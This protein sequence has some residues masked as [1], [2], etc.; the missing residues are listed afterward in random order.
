M[1]H[2]TILEIPSDLLERAQYG[3]RIAVCKH[4]SARPQ[5]SESL[6]AASPRSCEEK[7]ELFKQLPQ[8]LR[9]A[10]CIDPMVGSFE[11]IM[12]RHLEE[13]SQQGSGSERV[14]G[15]ASRRGRAWSRHTR[16]IIPVLQNVIGN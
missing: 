13:L 1:R 15:G 8:L 11:R 6:G 10:Q 2:L 12:E 9:T 3:L 16:R 14:L 5:G 4:C 7:C